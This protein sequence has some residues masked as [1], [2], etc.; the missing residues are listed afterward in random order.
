M[1]V[2]IMAHRIIDIPGGSTNYEDCPK[3][4]VIGGGNEPITLVI[5]YVASEKI[6]GQPFT[7]GE[8]TFTDVLEY[9]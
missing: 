2:N 1:E 4:K 8:I 6:E 5:Q 9:R 7:L 3:I